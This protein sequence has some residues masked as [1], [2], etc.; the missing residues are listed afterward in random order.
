MTKTENPYDTLGVPN[1]ASFPEVRAAYIKLA[2]LHHPDKLNETDNLEEHEEYFKRITLAYKKIENKEKHGDVGDWDG[3]G[4][5]GVGEDWGAIFKK[6]FKQAV[7]E[8]KKLYHSIEVPVSLE[9]IQNKKVKKLEI[10]LR[11]IEGPVYVKVNC[12]EWPSTTLIHDGYVIKTRF[13]LKDHAIYHLDDILGTRDLYTT[14]ELT[15]AEYLTGA[16][17]SILWCDGKTKISMIIPEFHDV[18][19]PIVF[20]GRGLWGQGDLYVKLHITPPPKVVWDTLT[21]PVRVSHTTFG[22]GVM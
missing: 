11:D 9:E 5:V 8:I 20:K 1:G 10:F 17:C 6:I 3:D 22:G 15:W 21:A 12:G 13:A 19:L 14:C 4:E 2:K 18:E 16:R 7:S